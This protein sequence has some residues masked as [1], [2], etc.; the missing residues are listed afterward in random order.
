MFY[1]DGKPNGKLNTNETWGWKVLRRLNVEWKSELLNE[2]QKWTDAR[3]AW[4]LTLEMETKIL[5]EN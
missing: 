4:K 2:N 1:T 5:N 3:M